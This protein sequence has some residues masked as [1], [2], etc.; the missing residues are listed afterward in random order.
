MS[1]ENVAKAIEAAGLGV[2]TKTIHVRSSP[3]EMETGVTL[4]PYGGPVDPELSG[5]RN[6]KFQVVARGKD[7]AAAVALAESVSHALTIRQKAVGTAWFYEV[8]PRDE[9]T[10][11]GRDASGLHTVLFNVDAIW[12]QL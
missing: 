9:P 7:F 5:I 12:R 8:N 6:L 4:V 2:M 11:F 3:A 1:I 10:P